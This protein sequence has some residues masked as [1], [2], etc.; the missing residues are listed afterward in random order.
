V[1]ARR[2]RLPAY[3]FT[4]A[5]EQEMVELYTSGSTLGEIREAYH[6]KNDSTLYRMLRRHGVALRKAPYTNRAAVAVEEAIKKASDETIDDLPVEPDLPP[7]VVG[8]KRYRVSMRVRLT[9]E[10]DSFEAAVAK[11]KGFNGFSEILTI[12]RIG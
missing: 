7:V 5:Q 11:A 1:T 12:S 8:R 9:F 10:A 6:Y 3:T 2:G 4:P